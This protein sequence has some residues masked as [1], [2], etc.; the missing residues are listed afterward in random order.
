MLFNFALRHIEAGNVSSQDI[1]FIM[2]GFRNKKS[3]DMYMKLTKIINENKDT[4]IGKPKEGQEQKWANNLVN[5]FY[6][7]ASNR[8]RNYGVYG[9]YAKDEL[10]E[11]IANYEQEFV[12]VSQHL[13]ADGLTRFAQVMYLLKDETFENIWWRIENRVHDLAEQEGAIDA[14]HLTN[15]LRSFSKS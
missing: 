12:D 10:R 13:D 7:F 15:I 5:L 2:Q 14:Y 8:P 4:L 11:I 3:K 9:N 1:H 6:S